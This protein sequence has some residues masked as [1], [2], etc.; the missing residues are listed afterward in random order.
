MINS[1]FYKFKE[2]IG[3]KIECVCYGTGKAIRNVS[4]ECVDCST[5][6]VDADS[7][8]LCP[9]CHSDNIANEGPELEYTCHN[10][11][12]QWAE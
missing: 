3:H 12:Y 2:H 5:V 4:I 1:Q 10:C 6:L 8:D 9:E 7:D 11:S